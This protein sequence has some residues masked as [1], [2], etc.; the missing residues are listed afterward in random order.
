MFWSIVAGISI[1]SLV[2]WGGAKL[3]S[4]G[5]KTPSGQTSGQT[6]S[7]PA[8]GAPAPPPST[9][10]AKTKLLAAEQYSDR[11]DYSMAESI[12]RQ[13]VADDPNNV[14][15][16]KGLASVLYREDKVDESAAILDRIPK[17]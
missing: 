8:P 15:A 6:F 16:L 13:I 1:L 11:K 14:E 3:A 4:S 7:T 10:D 17:N 12:Y 9:A 5:S 2:A